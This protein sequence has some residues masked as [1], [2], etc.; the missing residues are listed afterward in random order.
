MAT[1]IPAVP[2]AP[3]SANKATFPALADGVIAW[4]APG[5]TAM[6]AQ[7]AENNVINDNVNAKV[8][9]A[10]AAG[11]G[12]AAT[13][14]QTAT[15]KAAI[16][17]DKAAV[18]TDK[19]A[20]AVAAANAAVATSG[21]PDVTGKGGYFMRANAA[22]TGFE[23]TPGGTLPRVARTANTALT[24]ADIGKWIDCSGTFAQTFSACAAL[25][26]GWWC[27]VTNTGT[28]LITLMPNGAELID[29]AATRILYPGERRLMQ[30][31][32]LTIRTV[33]GGTIVSRRPIFA[34]SSAAMNAGSN[35]ERIENVVVT[36]AIGSTNA[37]IF[38]TNGT[39]V[40]AI[41][42]L[43]SPQLSSSSDGRTWTIRTL[44]VGSYDS[45]ASDG[46]GFLAASSSGATGSPVYSANG[47]S[48]AA[49][50]AMP[51]ALA[52]SQV[53]A[54]LSTGRY[55]AI[56]NSTGPGSVYLTINNGTSWTTETTPITFA[57]IL[58]CAGLFVGFAAASTTYYTSTTGAA[59]S[60]LSN[61]TP[62]STVT[63]NI[64]VDLDGSL[65]AFG[66]SDGSVWRS[67]NGTSWVQIAGVVLPVL[68]TFFLTIGGI[69]T[70]FALNASSI[71]TLNNGKWVN[72][73]TANQVASTGIAN[74]YSKAKIGNVILISNS[75]GKSILIDATAVDAATGLFD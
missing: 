41:T 75:N 74:I 45:I 50:T 61:V 52:T 3:S 36:P 16:A 34:A 13:N 43:A 38:A 31:D 58:S 54:G 42:A 67:I 37:A 14:A 1:I 70:N 21:L 35:F 26:T 28:G 59:G 73:P 2:T 39:N 8:A 62:G 22:A 6:N 12:N 29:G 19:A 25:A 7:S 18:A 9:A 33:E 72:R 46:S 23:L 24:F 71:Y 30:C 51:G 55:A 69:Y 60:W 64:R 17:T 65:I 44:P 47:T 56:S 27:R 48:W 57:F 63:T 15:D 49:A 4:L 10:L 66:A 40:V 11:L 68:N 53:L 5:T 20:I 32:G